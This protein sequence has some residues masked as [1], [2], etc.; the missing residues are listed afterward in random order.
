MTN[1]EFLSAISGAAQRVAAATGVPASVTIAQAILESR[2][3]LSDLAVK[4]NNLFGIK[5]DSRWKGPII[6]IP[7][8]E[9]LNNAWVTVP[10]S[11]RKYATYEDSIVDHAAFLKGARYAKA[12]ATKDPRTFITA[13][14][15]AGYATDPTYPVK[16]MQIITDRKL[17][18]YDV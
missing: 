1:I 5:A 2:W 4:A 8:R 10:A 16:I 15:Q 7:T 13:I 6:N 3:G 18:S 9:F 11:W 14:W 17:T 12:F